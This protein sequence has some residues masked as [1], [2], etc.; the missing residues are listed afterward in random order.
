[1][2]T[3]QAGADLVAV[4][5]ANTFSRFLPG[6]I[7]VVNAAWNDAATV[8]PLVNPKVYF[9]ERRLQ[10]PESP[11][12]MIGLNPATQTANGANNANAGWAPISYSFDAMLFFKGDKLHI[13]E[14]WGR[15][16]AQ[17]M[18]EV[19]MKHQHLD[20]GGTAEVPGQVG[21]DPQRWTPEAFASK[22][23]PL[24]TYAVTWSGLVYVLQDV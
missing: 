2:G 18:W 5:L 7:A 19:L 6:E 9:S 22:D 17:A 14:R 11:S 13:L 23:T 12:L 10:V 15:R 3:G 24:L 21:V 16:Y 20:E 8:P 1:M 4:A